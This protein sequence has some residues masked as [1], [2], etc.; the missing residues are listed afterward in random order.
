M[1]SQHLRVIPARQ[2]RKIAAS[3]ERVESYSELSLVAKREFA[4]DRQLSGF[5]FSD[6]H[7]VRALERTG[8]A[9]GRR[10]AV[11]AFLAGRYALAHFFRIV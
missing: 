11:L 2:H 10:D 5:R 8:S 4:M 1:P 9:A 3:D 7:S 6:C